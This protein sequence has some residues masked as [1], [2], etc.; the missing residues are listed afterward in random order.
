MGSVSTYRMQALRWYV[1][2]QEEMAPL[3]QRYRRASDARSTTKQELI[4]RIARLRA[5]GRTQREV[6]AIVGVSPGY[7]GK[8]ERRLLPAITRYRCQ[9]SGL[10]AEMR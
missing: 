9:V 7:V 10:D 1:A 3:R 6:A 2:Y 4:T 8:I 5:E